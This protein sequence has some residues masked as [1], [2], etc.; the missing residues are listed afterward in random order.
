MHE[1]KLLVMLHY[2]LFVSRF[3]DGYLNKRD[4]LKL[5]WHQVV[6]IFLMKTFVL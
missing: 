3:P 5:L 2:R 1:C 4:V 6:K